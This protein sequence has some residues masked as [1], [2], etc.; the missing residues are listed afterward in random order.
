MNGTDAYP[1]EDFKAHELTEIIWTCG[2]PS[3]RELDNII[4]E[5]FRKEKMKAEFPYA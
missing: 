4:R 2:T 5:W 1:S 3:K